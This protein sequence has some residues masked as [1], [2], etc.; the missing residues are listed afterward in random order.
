MSVP[1]LAQVNSGMESLVLMEDFRSSVPK[2]R[3]GGETTVSVGRTDIG[4]GILVFAQTLRGN[5]HKI[6]IGME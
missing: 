1:V 6:H 3:I 4:M 5:A 2:E